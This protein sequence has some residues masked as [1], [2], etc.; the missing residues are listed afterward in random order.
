LES[1]DAHQVQVLASWLE[2]AELANNAVFGALSE[3]GVKKST[4]VDI[5]NLI[6]IL[7]KDWIGIFREYK[8]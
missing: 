7:T 5:E 1:V 4:L 6:G 2:T 3:L 8:R